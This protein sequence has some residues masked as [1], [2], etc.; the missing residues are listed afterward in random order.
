MNDAEIIERGRAVIRMER[1]ALAALG[2]RIDVSF[3]N[4]VNMLAAADG[5]V[6]VS[7][8][9]KSG[10]IG[11]KI[12]ATFRSTGTPASFLHPTEA[13]HGDLGLVGPSDVALLISKSGETDELTPL[14]EQ[15]KRFGVPI[16]V[17]TGAVDS[18][19]A[20]QGDVFLDAS[21]VD[22]ACPTTDAPTTSTTVAL[23]LG[24]ALA[25]ALLSAKGFRREDFARL[26]PG[27]SLGRKL[28]TRVRDLMVSDEVPKLPLAAEMRE[29]VV[30]LAKRR[31][32]VAI[33][34][35]VNRVLGVI[36]AGDLTRLME[37]GDDFLSVPVS[38]VMNASPKIVHDDELASAGAYR[39]EQHGI[40]ALP[41]VDARERL[42][43]MIHLHDLMRAGI[44]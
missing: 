13:M 15:L 19:L 37:R 16:I 22:E 24:D 3:A 43:G 23:A 12:A 36:T 17:I 20:R 35:D 1:D 33:V 26:H 32:T 39:M 18:F 38:Q 29:A 6:I 21:V 2:S 28:V 41:V 14:M 7:G 44:L 31:G 40:M 8:V 25:V 4:A 30:L 10:L 27:G 5:Q 9:G 34:D 42:V 11:H